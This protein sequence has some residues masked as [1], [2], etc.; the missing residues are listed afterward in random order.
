MLKRMTADRVKFRETTDDLGCEDCSYGRGV[1]LEVY[2]ASVFVSLN[3]V[4]CPMPKQ[5]SDPRKSRVISTATMPNDV[6][7]NNA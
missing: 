6:S 7:K 4:Q 1:M 3:A 5:I 2:T